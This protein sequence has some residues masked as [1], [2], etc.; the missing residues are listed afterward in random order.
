MDCVSLQFPEQCS[1]PP[2]PSLPGE[3]QNRKPHMQEGIDCHIT[4]SPPPPPPHPYVFMLC[5]QLQSLVARTQCGDFFTVLNS[6]LEDRRKEGVREEGAGLLSRSVYREILFLKSVLS[7]GNIDIGRHT[8]SVILHSTSISHSTITHCHQICLNTSICKLSSVFPEKSLLSCTLMTIAPHH[9]LCSA[10][11]S[12]AASM[13]T[14]WL[15]RWCL[16]D[17]TV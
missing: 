7:D 13:S 17:R 10:G 9:E 12:L 3:T 5:R 4:S 8:T 15:N 2:T 6:L 1:F 16:S 11:E 14:D